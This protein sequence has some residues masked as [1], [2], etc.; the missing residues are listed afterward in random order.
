LLEQENKPSCP[1][2]GYKETEKIVWTTDI[3][4]QEFNLGCLNLVKET[5]FKFK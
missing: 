4:L 2:C 5:T 1:Y 3:E